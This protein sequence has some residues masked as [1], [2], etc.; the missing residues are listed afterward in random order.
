[1]QKVWGLLKLDKKRI[2]SEMNFI[3]LDTIGNA[4]VKKIPMTQLES[5]ITNNLVKDAVKAG[6]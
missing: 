3:L 1:M 2:S 6:D 4:I 5:L